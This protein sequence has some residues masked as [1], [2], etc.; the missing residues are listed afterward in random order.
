M[1]L[2]GRLSLGSPS[3]QCFSSTFPV[4]PTLQASFD[5]GCLLSLGVLLRLAAAAL[6]Y[7]IYCILDGSL[8]CKVQDLSCFQPLKM[9]F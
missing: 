2:C 5:A 8:T 7:E 9:S 4:V 1:P 6:N 3:W